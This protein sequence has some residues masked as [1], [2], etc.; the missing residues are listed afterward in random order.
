MLRRVVRYLIWI[1]GSFV[2]LNATGL[3]LTTVALLGSALAVGLGFGLQ[4]IF[5]NS[6]GGVVILA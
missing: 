4:S 3:D 2:A 5:A 1:V 6:V